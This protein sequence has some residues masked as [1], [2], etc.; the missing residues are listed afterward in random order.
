MRARK[1]ASIDRGLDKSTGVYFRGL[2]ERTTRDW[3]EREA[4][5]ADGPHGSQP[6]DSA[7]LD[8]S[9]EACCD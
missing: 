1:L 8:E 6:T 2:E 7:R 4:R 3:M 9:T 5:K